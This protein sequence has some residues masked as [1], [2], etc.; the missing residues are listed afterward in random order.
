MTLEHSIGHSSFVQ[1]MKD[2]S[3]RPFGLGRLFRRKRSNSTTTA[4]DDH[5][6]FL[7]WSEIAFS[8]DE[9]DHM[10]PMMTRLQALQVQQELQG[11]DHPDVLFSL[12]GI[13]K[14]HVRRGEYLQ[15]QLVEEI[16]S[17]SQNNLRS[18]WKSSHQI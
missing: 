12:K 3:K 4:S 17:A 7:D 18:T 14:A 1:Q 15:A 10:R 6:L 9:V 8:S 2:Q 5:R 13:S 11:M 16:I